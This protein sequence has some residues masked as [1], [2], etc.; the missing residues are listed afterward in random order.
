MLDIP[1]NMV[2]VPD[3][4]SLRGMVRGERSPSGIEMLPAD[5]AEVLRAQFAPLMARAAEQLSL[6]G[7]PAMPDVVSLLGET[8]GDDGDRIITG[9]TCETFVLVR[10]TR[11]STGEARQLTLLNG[12]N[13]LIVTKLSG[14]KPAEFSVDVPFNST[15]ISVR[16]PQL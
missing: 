10:E 6:P 3:L 11:P 12:D 5:Q 15:Q 8:F 16:L 9:Q 14:D 2:N 1:K 4:D 13:K 7:R